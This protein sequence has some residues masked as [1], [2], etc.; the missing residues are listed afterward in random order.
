MACTS[1][2]ILNAEANACKTAIVNCMTH[3]SFAAST[4]KLQCDKCNIGYFLSSDFSSCTKPSKSCDLYTTET[5]CNRC[6][7]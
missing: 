5:A 1:G 3:K 7:N 6:V 2:K 4:E